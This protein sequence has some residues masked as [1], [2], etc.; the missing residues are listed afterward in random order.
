MTVHVTAASALINRL[1]ILK[2]GAILRVS[3]YVS[4]VTWHF[5]KAWPYIGAVEGLITR[6]QAFWLFSEARTLRPGAVIVEIGCYKGRST[7]SLAYGC[8]GTT[9][10][11]FSIDTF[12]GNDTDFG[13][14]GREQFDYEWKRNVAENNL[15]GYVTQVVGDSTVIG[16]D[17]TSTID[18]LF[19]DG[20]HV[21]V[22]VLQDFDKFFP[23][24]V[25]GGVVALHDV[26][27]HDGP[28]QVWNERGRLLQ[29]KGSITNMAFGTKP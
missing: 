14:P 9:K 28:T 18:L 5:E 16:D 25:S 1:R 17:W 13:G 23:H 24:V 21:Y 10:R 3:K 22:D 4:P 8:Q 26:G 7:V 15:E 27:S 11:I 6:D 2:R 12:S 19:V 20:S 29:K